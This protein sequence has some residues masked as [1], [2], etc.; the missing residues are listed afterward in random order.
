MER[1][2]YALYFLANLAPRALM[3]VLLLVLTRLMPMGEYGLFV[4]VVT[5]GEIC[6][7]ALGNWVRVFALRSEGAGGRVRPRRLGR[8]VALTA[9]MTSVSLVVAVGSGLLRHEQGLGFAL[10]VSAY[11]LAF[12]P[13]R[14]SLILLQIRRMHRSYAAVEALR[15]G[16]TLA[17]ATAATAIAGPGFLAATLGLA[18]ATLLAGLV[19]LVRA[20][21]GV[22]RPQRARTGYGA[23]L[24]FGLPVMLASMLAH[25]IGLVDRYAVD[26]LMGPHAVAVL[27]AA[28]SLAR[29]PADLFLGPLNAYA[30]PHLVRLYE[31]EGAAATGRAQAGLLATLAIVG[32]AIVSGVSLLAVP[33]LAVALPEDYRAEGAV[34]IPW[35]AAGSLAIA[36]KFFIFDNAFHL[37]KRTWLQPPTMTPPALFGVVLCF[38]L[39]PRLGIVGAGISYALATLA[40]CTVT[41]FVTRRIIPIPLPW[42]VLARVAVANLGAGL[43]LVAA[44]GALD[45]LGPVAVLAGSTLA[46]V[47]V[48]AAL[49]HLFGIAVRRV[50]ETPWDPLGPGGP[51]G[52][53]FK[54]ALL[55][56]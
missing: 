5:T 38:V 45:P 31:Q 13:L 28:Y 20:M 2:A 10:A 51:A 17:A 33:L 16:G 8:L 26:M 18:G 23:A 4:L 3:F 27:A 36:A 19:G 6:D 47:A 32:G 46:F 40:A 53:C 1:A 21:R 34:L 44:R 25:A 43:T 42:R 11:L 50:V 12:A 9:A 30:F 49:L 14:L 29:Q 22:A 37:S 48:Y 39:V 54:P 41:A 15:A 56:G 24:A 35:I 55:K 7:M 52:A